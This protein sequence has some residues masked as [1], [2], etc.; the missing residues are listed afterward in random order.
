MDNLYQNNISHTDSDYETSDEEPENIN[1]NNLDYTNQYFLNNS[2]QTEYL[3][4]RNE[5]FTKDIIRQRILVDTHNIK[6][7]STNETLTTNNY[8]YYLNDIDKEHTTE[9]YNETGGYDR[10]KNVIGF[11]FI[12]AIIPNR[13]Y[14]INDTNNVVIIELGANALSNESHTDVSK[15]IKITLGKGYYTTETL[16]NAF[17]SSYQATYDWY[18]TDG[19]VFTDQ[20]SLHSTYKITTTFDGRHKKF[21]FNMNLSYTFKFSYED[22]ENEGSRN[23][24]GF[25]GSSSFGNSIIADQPPDMSV[26]YF[27]IVIPEIPY[28]TCKHNTDR[29]NVIER[30]PITSSNDELLVYEDSTF[31]REDQNFFFPISLNKLTIQL[32]QKNGKLF[33]NNNK[34]HSLEFEITM[35]NKV[36]IM[37]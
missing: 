17:D 25:T 13:T 2:S 24:L 20:S 29:R 18:T 7:K 36:D 8:T 19:T 21:T 23:L 1:F 11:R 33:D 27:D 28:I 16:T 32:Y 12:K 5:L 22:N 34:H 30:I 37:K 10:Y 15:K 31:E 26:H 4:K 6:N 9:N 3:T 14:N 35:I